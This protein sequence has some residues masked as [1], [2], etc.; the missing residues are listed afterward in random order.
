M[1]RATNLFGMKSSEEKSPFFPSQMSQ[2]DDF[3][4]L[5]ENSKRRVNCPFVL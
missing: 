4:N 5:G 2:S 1:N 3:D